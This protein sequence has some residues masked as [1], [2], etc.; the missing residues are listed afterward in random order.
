MVCSEHQCRAVGCG[1]CRA[2]KMKRRREGGMER[3]R[4]EGERE[5]DRERRGKDREREGKEMERER[6]E[7]D[8][9]RKENKGREAREEG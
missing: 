1:C 5:R 8:R 9:E 4:T 6:R 3:D 2:K 7:R